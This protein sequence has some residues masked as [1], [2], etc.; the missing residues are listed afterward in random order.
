MSAE[1]P[2]SLSS[3]AASKKWWWPTSRAASGAPAQPGTGKPTLSWLQARSMYSRAHK[4]LTSGNLSDGLA[5]MTKA[6][7]SNNVAALLWLGEY[8]LAHTATTQQGTTYLLRACKLG[9]AEANLV[10]GKY[11]FSQGYIVEAQNHLLAAEKLQFGIAQTD[12]GFLFFRKY[13]THFQTSDGYLA[14]NYIRYAYEKRRGLPPSA[15]PLLLLLCCIYALLGEKDKG[16]KSYMSLEKMLGQPSNVSNLTRW[17]NTFSLA[18]TPCFPDDH[19][20]VVFYIAHKAKGARI[21]QVALSLTSS[22]NK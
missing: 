9:S 22:P 21:S 5:L 14:E 6:A 2:A 11:Y 12:L 1:I 7:S 4:L 17:K 19:M 10:L 3:A 8:Y 13:A 15:A 18:L 16:D 20:S